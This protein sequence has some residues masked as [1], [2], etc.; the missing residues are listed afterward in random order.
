LEEVIVQDKFRERT[1]HHNGITYVYLCVK[2]LPLKTV[3]LR[4]CPESLDMEE[5]TP[6]GELKILPFPGR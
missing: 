4:A 6:P 1:T 5:G 2:L 3:L